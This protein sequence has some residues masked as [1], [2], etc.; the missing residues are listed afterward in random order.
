M[1]KPKVYIIINI[2]DDLEAQIR[3]TCDAEYIDYGMPREEFLAAIHDAEG[4]LLSPRVRADKAFFDAAP[5]AIPIKGNPLNRLT[6]NRYLTI[7]LAH[8]QPRHRLI[9]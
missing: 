5:R 6:K 2:E 8:M 1:S 4:I 7:G 9:V 3:T